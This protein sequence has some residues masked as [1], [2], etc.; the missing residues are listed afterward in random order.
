MRSRPRLTR[1]LACLAWFLAA[2]PA[3]GQDSRSVTV[4][5]DPAAR[6]PARTCW[7]DFLGAAIRC[8]NLDGSAETVVAAASGPYGLAFDPATGYLIWTS[9]GDEVVQAA[10][11]DGSGKI[12]TL[13]GSFEEGY[14]I[15]LPEGDARTVY[16]VAENQ[17]V[18]ITQDR[19]TG[20][21][22]RV[23]LLEL[24]SPDAVHGLA[25]SPDHATLYLGDADGRMSQKLG[26]GDLRVE[27]LVFTDEE[28]VR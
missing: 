18:Q 25:L 8:S 6:K 19:N 1:L 12:V 13:E 9:S 2:L 11:A 7:A 15:L 27:P 16:G 24:P 14:A 10:P 5:S 26:L 3:L 22:K 21:E 20:D 4:P 23:V 17:V 28:N